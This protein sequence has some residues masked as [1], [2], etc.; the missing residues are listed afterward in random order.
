M[1]RHRC[2]RI[3]QDLRTTEVG[4]EHVHLLVQQYVLWFEVAMDDAEP[5]KVLECTENLRR[6]KFGAFD[7]ERANLVDIRQELA[8]FRVRQD[9][10]ES[11]HVLEGAE[12][13][14]ERMLR[15]REHVQHLLLSFHVLRLLLLDDM[16]FVAHFDRVLLPRVDIFGEV[17]LRGRSKITYSLDRCIIRGVRDRAQWRRVRE[18]DGVE[19]TGYWVVRQ[20]KF[21]GRLATTTVREKLSS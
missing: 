12:Q 8:V 2:L 15:A 16:T 21:Q 13:T 20:K 9:E 11:L 10:I 14:H 3:F 1:R 18:Y 6:I 5:V 7:V 17:N 4:N 19:E